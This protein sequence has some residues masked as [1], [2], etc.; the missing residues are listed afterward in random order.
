[1]PAGMAMAGVAQSGHE[2]YRAHVASGV[3][4]SQE[5]E[6][7]ILLCYVRR[8]AEQPGVY[9]LVPD[10]K[11]AVRALRTYQEGGHCGDGIHHLYAI[12]P[13]GL[14]PLPG[15]GHQCG[16]HAVA[17]DHGPQRPRRRSDAGATGGGPHM[18]PPLPLLLSPP[19]GLPGPVLTFPHGAGQL[20][21]G[22]SLHSGT[23]RI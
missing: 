8:L 9:W 11:A 23:G 18:A 5:G 20:V 16:H 13:G 6:A 10:S 1:M 15:L 12:V 3:G 19:G 7:M 14:P 2:A 4:T 17:L 22:S 21:A